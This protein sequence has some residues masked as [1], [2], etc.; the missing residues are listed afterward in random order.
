MKT[1]SNETY[2]T[3]YADKDSSSKDETEAENATSDTNEA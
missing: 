3:D 1:A 2:Q